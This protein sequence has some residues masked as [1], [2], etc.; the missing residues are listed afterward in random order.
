MYNVRN[1]VQAKGSK[2]HVMLFFFYYYD[3]NYND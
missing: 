1:G 3:F 2:N